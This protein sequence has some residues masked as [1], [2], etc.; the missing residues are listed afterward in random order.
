[1]IGASNPEECPYVGL[2]AFDA[3]YSEFFFG[4]SHDSKVIADHVIARPVT[5]LYGPSGIGKSSIL[6]VGL[7]AALTQR[8]NW[9]IA[10]LRDWQDPDRLELLAVEAVL[11][12][13]RH[14]PMRP[15]NRLRL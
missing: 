11:N 5:V 13:L 7:P 10:R 1:M 14:R 15:S 4:R 9:I 6:N 2:D 12:E 3:A 8:A